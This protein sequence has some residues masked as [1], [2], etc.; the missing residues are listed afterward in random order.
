M[1]ETRAPIEIPGYRNWLEVIRTYAACERVLTERCRHAGLTLA[2]HDVLATLLSEGPLRQSDLASRLFVVKSNV[3]AVLN[4]M[5]R[6][7]LVQR[8]PDP[9]D[10]RANRIVPTPEGRRRAEMSMAAQQDVARGM[11][12]QLSPNECDALG[13]MMR[14]VRAYLTA[15]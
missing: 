10:G 4:R 14:R 8:T 15:L 5:E 11:I 1:T 7:G 13:E 12:G 9:A 3:V 6:D 2:Q